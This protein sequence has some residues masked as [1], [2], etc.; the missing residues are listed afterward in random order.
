MAYGTR[1]LGAPTGLGVLWRQNSIRRNPRGNLGVLLMPT[2]QDSVNF[3]KLRIR[4]V[5]VISR[6]SLTSRAWEL[7]NHHIT[8]PSA[9]SR[10]SSSPETAGPQRCTRGPTRLPRTSTAVTITLRMKKL[11]RSN[12]LFVVRARGERAPGHGSRARQR[13]L[14]RA[15]CRIR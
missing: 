15:A 7:A 14:R 13:V 9:P 1:L 6:L 4:R 12:P 8:F 10:D 5:W 3:R 2:A 11:A